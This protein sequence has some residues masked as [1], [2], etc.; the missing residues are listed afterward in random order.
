MINLLYMIN[1]LLLFGCIGFVVWMYMNPKNA[2]DVS[3]K[4][5][6]LKGIPIEVTNLKRMVKEL[7]IQQ[8][9]QEDRMYVLEGI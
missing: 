3:S 9:L 5:N 4:F 1:L 8:K 7:Q 6:E 2:K